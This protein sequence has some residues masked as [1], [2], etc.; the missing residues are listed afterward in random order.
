MVDVYAD[1]EG[2]QPGSLDRVGVR[3]LVRLTSKTVLWLELESSSDE[4]E[5]ETESY[6]C[7]AW[8]MSMLTVRGQ[9]H[10]PWLGLWLVVW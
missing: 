7:E 10:A 2:S 8:V 6:Y 9:V 1:S 3:C 4:G 5:G